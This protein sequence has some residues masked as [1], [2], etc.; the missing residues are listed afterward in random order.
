MQV[1]SKELCYASAATIAA[2]VGAICDVRS[3]KIPNR[4]TGGCMIAGFILHFCLNGWGGLGDSALAGILAGVGFLLLYV[5]RGMGAGDVKLMMAI[6]C[7]A[8]LARLPLM[9]VNT[10]VFGAVM[11][12]VVAMHQ[13]Q[14]RLTLKR[15]LNILAGGNS[16][17]TAPHE[18]VAD[19][20]ATTPELSLSLP[21]AVPIAFGCMCSL[22]FQLSR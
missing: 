12:V 19:Q 17:P 1:W 18:S 6:G 10:V 7:L 22:Y 20:Q 2:L 13:R 14:L 11:A 9:L 8:G 16:G 3:R 21:F 4:L 5:A 15:V